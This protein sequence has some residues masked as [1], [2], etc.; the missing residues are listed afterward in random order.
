VRK[1]IT[2]TTEDVL[3]LD[4]SR[5]EANF[6]IKWPYANDQ[7]YIKIVDH[8]SLEKAYTEDDSGEFV[9][10][11]ALECRGVEPIAWH[12]SLDFAVESTGGTPFANVD[13]SDRDWAEFDEEH[14]LSVS[15]TDVEYK[16]EVIPN[17]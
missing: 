10:I 2:I 3:P 6:I 5:G 7:A 16:I 14:D 13:L 1:D 8:K 17:K 11:L 15:I 9:S 12:P 4:G